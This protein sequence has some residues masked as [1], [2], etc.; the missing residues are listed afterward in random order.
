MQDLIIIKQLKTANCGLKLFMFIKLCCDYLTTT[1][2]F[3][4]NFHLGL[5]DTKHS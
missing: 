4:V 1:N 5:F 3:F 2:P